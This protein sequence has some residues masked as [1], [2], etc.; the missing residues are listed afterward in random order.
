MIDRP[1]TL[2]WHLT[3]EELR[4]DLLIH[5][6]QHTTADGCVDAIAAACDKDEIGRIIAA[7]TE[8]C[9]RAPR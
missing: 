8:L 9:V 6:L 2:Y 4:H 3:P 5:C 7:L 1:W